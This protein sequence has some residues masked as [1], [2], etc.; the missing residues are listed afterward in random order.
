MGKVRYHIDRSGNSCVAYVR[1]AVK[2]F[3]P[4]LHLR[5]H[6]GKSTTGVQQTRG[7]TSAAR[8]HHARRKITNTPLKP[9]SFF[10]SVGNSTLLSLKTNARQDTC[11][12]STGFRTR[13]TRWFCHITLTVPGP[14]LAFSCSNAAFLP[15]NSSRRSR[16]ST[17]PELFSLAVSLSTCSWPP[18]LPIEQPS[19]CWQLQPPHTVM[20][21][22]SSLTSSD[23]NEFGC[24]HN[25]AS[26]ARG[27]GGVFTRIDGPHSHTLGM[28]KILEK[29]MARF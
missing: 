27:A 29:R 11:T 13:T 17:E 18:T 21:D 3:Q 24:V 28:S 9:C 5:Q 12:V 19:S 15:C 26:R 4:K 14:R 16:T 25:T 1:L 20:E 22:D 8:T 7:N 6:A 10:V 2:A 23:K